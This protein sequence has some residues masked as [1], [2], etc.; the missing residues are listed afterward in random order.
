MTMTSFPRISLVAIFAALTATTLL[1]TPQ[2]AAAQAA[3]MSVATPPGGPLGLANKPLFLNDSVAPLNMLVVG[4]DHKLYYE[5]Y[6]DASDLNGDGILDVGFK[7]SITYFGLFDSGKCYTYVGGLF[8]PAGAAALPNNTCTGQ[9]SGNFLNYVTTARIDAL[10]KVLYGGSRAVDTTTTTV[11]QRTHVPQDAHSWGK[12]YESIARDGYDITQFTPLPMPTAGTR[13]LIANTT[14]L[15]TGM[16]E[17]RMRVLLNRNARIWNWVSRER[18]VAETTVD[19]LGGGQIPTDYFVYV[20]VCVAGMEEDNCQNYPSGHAKPVGLLQE[21]GANDKMLF[22]LLSGSYKNNTQGGVLRKEVG[23]VSDEIDPVNGTFLPL[24]GIIRNLDRL[25]TTE[26]PAHLAYHYTCGWITDRPINPGECEMW[27]NPIGEM[28]YE[29]MRY[30]AGKGAP[31]P[32]FNYTGISSDATLGLT[33]GNWTDPYTRFPSCAKPFQ[34]VISDINPS[35]DTDSVPGSSFSGFGGDLPG[36]VAGNEADEIWAGEQATGTTIG[37]SFFIGES[38]GTADG[39]PTVKNV[40]GFSNIRGLAPEDPTKQGGYYSAAAAFYGLKTDLN[41]TAPGKQ[42]LQTFAVALASPLP[43]IEIPVN[44]RKITLVPFAK[45]VGGGYGINPAQGA[46]QPTNTIV[47]FYVDTITPTSG[48]FRV[49]FEDVEQGADHDMDAIVRYDYVVNPDN[50]VD[51]T[52]TSEYAA[53]GI[54]QH[55][56]YVISGTTADGTYLEVRDVDTGAAADPD[57]FLDTP[58]GGVWN[59]G[60]ALPFTNT[61]TFTPGA[62]GAASLLRDPLWYAAKWGGFE[63]D[64]ATADNVPQGIEFDADGNGVPDNYFLV[65]NAL[66][67]KDQLA[68]AFDSIQ[69]KVASASAA[70]V[71]TASIGGDS[72]VY[73]SVFNPSDWNGDIKAYP[74]LADGTIGAAEAW[75]ASE[76]VPAPAARKIVT[77][78][79]AGNAQ[80]FQWGTI[81][82]VRESDLQPLAD[83]LAQER[84]NFLRGDRSRERRNGGPFRNR[85]PD[86]VLG[87]FVSS[88]PVYVGK[89]EGRFGTV[90]PEAASYLAFRAAK[91][92]RPTALYAGANDGMLH[93]FDAETGAERWAFIPGAV[94][95]NLHK[96]TDPNYSH[97]YF[98]DGAATVSD[99]YLGS[100]GTYLVSGLN[101]GG[102]SVFALD[103]T[104]PTAASE[105]AVASKFLWEFTDADDADLGYTYSRPSIARMANGDWV[106]I[107][108]NGYNNTASDGTVSATGNAVLYIVRLSDGQ[109]LRKIDTGVGVAQDPFGVG[110]PNGLST[111]GVVDANQDAVADYAYAG[112]LF[113]NLW[114]FDLTSANPAGWVAA[115]GGGAI[116]TPL[117]IARD[118]FGNRQPIT[119]RPVVG[120]GPGGDGLM[121][122]FGTG[123]FLEA[124]DRI[125]A[126][127]QLHTF[128][129]LLDQNTGA[130]GTDIIANRGA[131][132]QQTITFE[133][134]VTVSDSETGSSKTVKARVTSQNPL[135][136]ERGWYIDLL[137]PAAGFQGEM[138]PSN[139]FLRNKRVN[140]TTLIPDPDPCT[141]GGSSW[142]MN[143]DM[144]SGG[145][146]DTSPFDLNN[147]G[148]FDA[149]DKV[150]PNGGPS[151]VGSDV[152]VSGL[153]VGEGIVAQGIVVGDPTRDRDVIIA[154]DS[155]GNINAIPAWPGPGVYGRQ[156][157]RQLR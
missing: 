101:A 118:A 86:N 30:F 74:F 62:N 128:Y 107:F 146:I 97:E 4:R 123:K 138:V 72:K 3:P 41:T 135:T 69:S 35:Y 21:Y 68:T 154:P 112:D 136:T 144:F 121:V 65:T 63:E 51:V 147:D 20:Q 95:K 7:P 126:N 57:Y 87:D 1:A 40:A 114:K 44:G 48:S 113:G 152:A 102:Q 100:W 98:V 15:K 70:S 32:A 24:V 29:T 120:R 73:Q 64:T 139:P 5:A 109:L 6:N 54:I 58:P 155:F 141:Y 148:D 55:M 76:Q 8:T 96:L 18:P 23:T 77:V 108:G 131:L 16:Q 116:K 67:L 61:R 59:D 22:G 143:I 92:T 9:W 130:A 153:Q 71:N 28:M 2:N 38:N 45:S 39:A 93:A 33:K 137:S 88:A 105:G 145:R 11:L 90:I 99:A 46:F 124:R 117:Y 84:L 19:T 26:F 127:L 12:E 82:A 134:A 14:V 78:D 36:F 119:G 151:A 75:I 122:L 103:V 110:R 47:D 157:W 34:T 94:F 42:N 81:G 53:G 50:T 142:I 111:V 89:P 27:G 17:P 60:V 91:N 37:N 129:G 31:T 125:P 150:P 140:F 80:A 49:N 156:S 56:G 83:G 43:R 85:N 52:L 133:G 115:Y 132:L 104:D 13:H 66:T 10:R 149:E 106:A 25:K 79:A